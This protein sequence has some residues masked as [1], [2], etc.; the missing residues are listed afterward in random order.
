LRHTWQRKGTK[1]H[2]QNGEVVLIWY[3]FDAGATS[4]PVSG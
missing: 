2:T 1:K 3:S 4:E